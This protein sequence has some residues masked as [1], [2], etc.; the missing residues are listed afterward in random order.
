M[1]EY[2]QFTGAQTAQDPQFNKFTR[3]GTLQPYYSVSEINSMFGNYYPKSE[4]YTKTDVDG[5][6]AN[7]LDTS[8]EHIWKVLTVQ[9][10][11]QP[12]EYVNM[13]N[14][15]EILADRAERDRDG[16][17]ITSTYATNDSLSAYAKELWVKNNFASANNVYA[18][19]ETSGK[20]QLNAAFGNKL[21]TSAAFSAA[22]FEGGGTHGGGTYYPFSR[23]TMYGGTEAYRLAF[24]YASDGS[25]EQGYIR[26]NDDIHLNDK[27][28]YVWTGSN[29]PDF[30]HAQDTY[31][32][33]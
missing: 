2:W 23:M 14:N 32:I 1:Q 31:Y 29:M 30:E 11:Q 20:E 8:A 17:F 27:I 13:L 24:A 15:M 22:Y 25:T 18:K 33:I 12:G 4:L 21:D 16:N 3:I 6:L 28:L 9:I 10:G 19:N 26:K 7:K 5:K